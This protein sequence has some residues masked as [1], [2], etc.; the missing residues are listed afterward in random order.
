ML[1]LLHC[2]TSKHIVLDMDGT[3]I[4]SNDGFQIIPRTHLKE[5]LHFL[6]THP[7]IETV[8]IWTAASKKWFDEVYENCLRNL[9]PN[10]KLFYL[11][12]T[13]DRCTLKH[14]YDESKYG[15]YQEEQFHV[16]KKLRK[17][18][19]SSSRP[20]M[21]H[22]TIIID[23]TPITYSKNYGNAIRVKTFEHDEDNELL[24]L[25]KYLDNIILHLSN[26]RFIEKRWWHGHHAT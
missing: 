22:N 3:L 13:E 18:W 8:S 7:M 4:S 17:M 23:D 9:L 14:I 16:V 6:F 10:G 15:W 25:M 19:K 20:H 12:W 2:M 1:I 5:F 24:L 26:V 11:I 21:E